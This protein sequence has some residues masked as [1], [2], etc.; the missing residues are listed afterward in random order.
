MVEY[1]GFCK[2]SS[3]NILFLFLKTKFYSKAVEWGEQK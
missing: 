2:N 3:Y 1:F